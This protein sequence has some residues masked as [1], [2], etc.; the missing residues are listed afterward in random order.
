M[1]KIKTA[2]QI[3]GIRVASGMLVEV[4]SAL[5]QRVAPGITTADLD[6]VAREMIA[7][8]NARPAFLGYMGFP[9]ALCTSVDSAV[10][11]GIPNETPLEE[12]QVVTVDCGVEYEG[13]YSDSALTIPV[14]RVADDVQRL[15]G[16]T[17]ES[18][19]LGIEQA[20]V[21]NRVKDISRA[22]YEHVSQF[23]YGV[24][25]P[26]CG[27]GVGLDIH[28]DPQ[29]PNYVGSGP[30]PRLKPGMV[31]AIEPMINLG[32]DDIDVLDDDWTVVTIDGSVSAHFEHTVAIHSDGTEILTS[33]NGG[34]V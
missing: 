29:I 14:G 22:V 19:A 27:H 10:I 31:V 23:G 8:R 13:Y 15:M 6:R 16:V 26:Y 30:N 2:K 17:K 12:G 11:H 9:A 34:G 25:R 20:R 32:G 1:I 24:V 21:G 28:E 18:L 7:A 3:E 33:R 5:E 4:L